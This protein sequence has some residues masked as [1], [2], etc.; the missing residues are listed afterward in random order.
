VPSRVGCETGGVELLASGPSC[1]RPVVG[2]HE[3]GR[4]FCSRLVGLP[5]AAVAA[6]AVAGLASRQVAQVASPAVQRLFR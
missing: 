2:H 1:Q 4:W 3:H 5:A 6:L